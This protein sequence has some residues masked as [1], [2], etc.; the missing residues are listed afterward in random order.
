MMAYIFKKKTMTT[1]H[2]N[3]WTQ[4]VLK[5]SVT[6]F[7]KLLEEEKKSKFIEVFATHVIHKDGSTQKITKYTRLYQNRILFYF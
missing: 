6:D 2:L 3:E 1:A 5:I 7:D 4:I